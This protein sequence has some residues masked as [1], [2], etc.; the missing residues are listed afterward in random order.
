MIK[1]EAKCNTLKIDYAKNFTL[2]VG[3]TKLLDVKF[4]F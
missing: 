2:N 4:L 3:Y 1:R